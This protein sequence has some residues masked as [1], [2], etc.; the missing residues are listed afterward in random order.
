VTNRPNEFGLI[1]KYFAPLA[2]EG[3]FGLLDDAALMQVPEGKQL[4]VTQ[5]ALA[6]GVHFFADDPPHLIAKKALRVNISDL[7]AKGATPFA[8]SLALGLD[9][10]WTESWIAEFARGL[11]EDQAEFDI[12]LTGG[13]TF[14]SPGGVTLSVTAFG[15]IDPDKYTS[16]LGAQVGD[17]L[18]VTGT[19]GDAALGLKAVLEEL[20]LLELTAQE[21]NHLIDAY[22]LPQ[23][24]LPMADIIGTYASASMD[25][26]DGL[27]GDLEK[28]CTA[29]GVGAE[30]KREDIPFSQPVKTLIQA[31][32]DCLETALT[33]G[34][35]Y[36]LLFTIPT[37]KL[38]AFHQ[39]IQALPTKVSKIGVVN[40]AANGV[41]L[42]DNMGERLSFDTTSYKHF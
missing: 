9:E 28:L 1:A 7:V 36:Q 20:D 15:L 14:R 6:A 35:D 10:A 3:A 22:L 40:D 5:D 34:D 32:P 12:T 11:A 19:I 33:G 31:N 37:D 27:L 13:D 18:F 41:R 8:Y 26:S 29:S 17:A 23:P 25:I 30:V 24:T 39:A 21:T 2:G 4:V 16:R 38:D 42:L